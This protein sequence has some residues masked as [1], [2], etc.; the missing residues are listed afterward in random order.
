MPSVIGL[1]QLSTSKTRKA[2]KTPHKKRVK[3]ARYKVTRS[4][5]EEFEDWWE[6]FMTRNGANPSQIDEI[7]HESAE[8]SYKSH[9]LGEILE[10]DARSGRFKDESLEDFKRRKL[11]CLD[12]QARAI[13]NLSE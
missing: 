6:G 13:N 11:N 12:Q 7:K 3:V 2:S 9:K 1:K 5:K 8:F 4:R 10:K